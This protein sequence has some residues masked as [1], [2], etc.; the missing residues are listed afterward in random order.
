VQLDAAQEDLFREVIPDGSAKALSKYTDM[1]DALIRD[2]NDRLAA[3]SDDARLRLR[4]W[5][6]PD[7]LQVCSAPCL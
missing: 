5:D 4:E 2:Q 6:L 3:A 1:V 7:C